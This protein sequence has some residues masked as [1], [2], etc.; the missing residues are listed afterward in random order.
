[1]ETVRTPDDRFINLPGH[2]F[3]PH[4]LSV[5]GSRSR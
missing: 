1:M 4:Y 5:D 3:A 2:S